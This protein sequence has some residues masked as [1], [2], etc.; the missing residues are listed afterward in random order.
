VLAGTYAWTG[1]RADDRLS[2]T[3]TSDVPSL[4]GSVPESRST[5]WLRTSHLAAA[6]IVLPVVLC[7]GFGESTATIGRLLQASNLLAAL[8]DAGGC[9]SEDLL[10]ASTPDVALFGRHLASLVEIHRL[11]R[12]YQ[13]T[14]FVAVVDDANYES[15]NAYRTAGAAAVL[16]LSA[17]RSRLFATVLLAASGMA[18]MPRRY[19][20]RLPPSLSPRER[21]LVALLDSELRLKQVADILGVGIETTRSQTKSIYKKFG[22]H[23][24]VDLRA[25]LRECE[26]GG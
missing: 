7:A 10:S 14:A 2:A 15:A 17:P 13:S 18:V 1:A 21:E 24:R 16:P 6:S 20:Q 25:R 19:R 11:S 8:W 3:V 4:E 12:I 22:V 23:A 9:D 5:G 26:A